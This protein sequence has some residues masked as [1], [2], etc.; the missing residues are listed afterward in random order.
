MEFSI[1]IPAKN[2]ELNLPR[3]LASLAELESP[4]NI[5]EV[6]L[7]DNGSSDQTVGIAERFGVKVFIRPE[8]TI[9]G[10]RNFGASRAQGQILA[11]L[12][13][14]CTVAPDWLHAASIW[15][16]HWDVCCFGSPPEAPEDGTWVQKAWFIIRC[17]QH[18][19]ED[20]DWL[21]S[22]NMF[23]RKDTF[24]TVGGFDEGLITC[25]DY[26]LSLRLK[27]HGRLVADKRIRAIHHGEAATLRRFYQ[28]ESWRG[29]S[30]LS[31]LLHHGVH[32]RELPSLLTPLIYFLCFVVSIICSVLVLFGV[33]NVSFFFLTLWLILWQA[34]ILLLALLKGPIGCTLKLRLQLYLLLNL[35]FLARGITM[36]R[37]W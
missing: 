11:F 25:E 29:R 1:I 2:E 15:R 4:S 36:L 27:Q 6:L 3:C 13:A 17:K 14:D 26:D 30:N 9:A 32:W 21:E 19:V 8:A 7:I 23:T 37:R 31:G 33:V 12:D 22:M 10:L 5:Y 20:V 24:A 35:Y 18:M 16:E 28:K 34:P